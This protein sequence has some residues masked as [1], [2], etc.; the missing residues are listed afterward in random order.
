MWYSL[1]PISSNS[2][3]LLILRRSHK[4]RAWSLPF[5]MTYRPSPLDD[6]Y[7]IPSV[8]P[9]STP[10]GF[11]AVPRDLRSL[12]T[13]VSSE[14]NSL[15]HAKSYPLSPNLDKSIIRSTYQHV[16][17]SGIR[18]AHGIDIIRMCT[19]DPHRPSIGDQV[20]DWKPRISRVSGNTYLSPHHI[21]AQDRLRRPRFRLQRICT[22]KSRTSRTC[23]LH[24]TVMLSDPLRCRECVPG[25]RSMTMK[26]SV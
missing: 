13:G 22:T 16:P 19:T 1:C 25:R 10:D 8:C 23:F 17:R 21:L 14:R 9:T 2:S 15:E 11:C 3:L 26:R 7:V 4:R 18:P 20:I 12:K 5:E 6:T 24:Q